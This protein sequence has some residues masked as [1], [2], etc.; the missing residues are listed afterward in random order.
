MKDLYQENRLARGNL[1]I[2]GRTVDLAAV[3]MPV[4]NIYS[5]TDHIIPP[6]ASKAMRGLVGSK[7][8]TEAVA[9][10]GHI[11]IFR[12][13]SQSALRERIVGWV[14]GAKPVVS[15]KIRLA[16]IRVPRLYKLGATA[17]HPVR[18]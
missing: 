14:R 16:P 7:D 11:G 4:L 13:R 6:P 1:V 5:E 12:G 10:G 8:Y 17:R 9:V 3:A 2:G 18:A 15:A